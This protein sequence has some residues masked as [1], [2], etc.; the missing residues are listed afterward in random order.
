MDDE[1][2]RPI[3]VIF[4]AIAFVAVLCAIAAIPIVIVGTIAITKRLGEW[5]SG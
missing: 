2:D 3:D 4:G 5:G 1:K